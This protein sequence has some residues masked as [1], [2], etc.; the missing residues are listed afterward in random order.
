MLEILKS[1]EVN[2]KGILVEYDSGYISPKDNKHFINEVNKC[3]NMAL[4]IRTKGY[5]L[6]IF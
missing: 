5:T 6:K 4:K 1:N 2:K 3:R